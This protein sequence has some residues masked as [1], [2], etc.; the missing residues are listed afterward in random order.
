MKIRK[1]GLI[2]VV[3]VGLWGCNDRKTDE[4]PSKPNASEP[5]PP[6]EKAVEAHPKLL[7]ITASV[8]GSERFIFTKDGVHYEHRFWGE[9]KDVTFDGEPWIDLENT[10]AGWKNLSAHLDLTKARITERKGRDVVAL[11]QTAD[12]FD[13]YLCDSPNGYDN[14]EVTIAIPGRQ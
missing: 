1:L 10:P 11:E 14:Y 9:P 4:P 12:G 13:L 5:A 6:T 7:R 2:L 8:D 3:C